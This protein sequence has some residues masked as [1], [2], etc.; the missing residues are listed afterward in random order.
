MGVTQAAGLSLRWF[1]DELAS[2][3]DHDTAYEQLTKEAAV[4]PA[5]A[6]V[7]LWA[8]ISWVSGPHIGILKLVARS[9][10][11]TRTILEDMLSAPFSQVS[12]SA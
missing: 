11:C 9:S 12:H 7:L 2:S 1:R 6:E 10:G 3:L 5:S 4:T 8:S